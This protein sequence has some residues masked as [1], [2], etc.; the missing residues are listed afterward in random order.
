[1]QR[2][3]ECKYRFV[4]S[5]WRR[6]VSD[7]LQWS[8]EKEAAFRALLHLALDRVLA[9]LRSG[10]PVEQSFYAD[11]DEAGLSCLV[12]RHGQSYEITALS[13]CYGESGDQSMGV[14]PASLLHEAKQTLVV[15]AAYVR[16]GTLV[17][18]VVDGDGLERRAARNPRRPGSASAVRTRKIGLIC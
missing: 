15:L 9:R 17:I 5:A 4:L 2:V 12:A 10:K 14:D 7:R 18:E 1:M 11:V 13:F 3:L 6:V 16:G 8:D